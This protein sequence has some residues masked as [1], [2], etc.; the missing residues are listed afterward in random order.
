M[1]LLPLRQ[2]P[3]RPNDAVAT[4]WLERLG[5]ELAAPCA[6]WTLICRG[7]LAEISYP[8]YASNLGTAVAHE[9][10]PQATRLA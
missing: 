2:L 10:L 6:Y 3:P 7:T 8:D 4:A 9:R 1:P 5:G